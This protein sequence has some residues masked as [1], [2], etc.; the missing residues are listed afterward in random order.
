MFSRYRIKEVEGKFIPQRWCFGWE[1]IDRTSRYL[2]NSDENQYE[3]CAWKTLEQARTRIQEY[4]G[5]K[6]GIKYHKV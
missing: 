3:W 2:W 6:D 5:Y 1:G 4:R